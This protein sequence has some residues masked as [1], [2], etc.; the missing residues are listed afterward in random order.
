MDAPTLPSVADLVLLGGGHSHVICVR[1]LGMRPVPGVRVTL[2]SKYGEQLDFPRCPSVA[3]LSASLF[4]SLRAGVAR[5]HD[6]LFWHASWLRG[7]GVQLR[8]VPRCGHWEGGGGRVPCG[9][10]KVCLYSSPLLQPDSRPVGPRLT[11]DLQR[12]CSWAGVRLVVAEATGLDLEARRVL[13]AGR[14]ALTFDLLSIDVGL[15][16]STL[17]MGGAEQHATR[18]KPI[19]GFAARWQAM[20]AR[21]LQQE[22]REEASVSKPSSQEASVSKPLSPAR[23]VVVGGGAGGVELAFAMNHRLACELRARGR[24]PADVAEVHLVTRGPLLPSHPQRLRRLAAEA[25]ARRGIF[26]HEGAAVVGVG[27]TALLRQDGSSLPA[28]EVILCTEGCGASWLRASGL[29]VDAAGFV[30]VDATLRSVSHPHVFAA[31]DVAAVGPHPRPK[32]GVFAVR[33]GAPLAAN[34]RAVLEVNAC[35]CWR[36]RGGGL[37][38]WCCS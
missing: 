26:L 18:V 29:A 33:Q 1:M 9:Q 12:L 10:C 30:Q 35:S 36:L 13:L 2:V 27:S 14:P 15:T 24:R 22:P 21:L 17:G 37:Y 4:F 25:M 7:G 11:V 8:R 3:T 31:G 6:A 16:P 23:V 34:L 28:D 38:S 5:P 32:A 19:D 20:L